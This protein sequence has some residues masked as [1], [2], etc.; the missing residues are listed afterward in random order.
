MLFG[1]YITG[2]VNCSQ[3]NSL[4]KEQIWISLGRRGKRHLR[5]V[6]VRDEEYFISITAPAL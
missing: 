6:A 3:V 2:N 4:E 5:N 1:I